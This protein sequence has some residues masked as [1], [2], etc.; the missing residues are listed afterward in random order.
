MG[1]FVKLNVDGSFRSS[2]NLMCVCGIVCTL[3]SS[4]VAGFSASFHG[5]CPLHVKL[6]TLK[7]G[8]LLAWDLGY[9]RLICESH[10]LDV[11]CLLEPHIM[12][13]LLYDVLDEVITIVIHLWNVSFKHVLHEAN[14]C[15]HC[16]VAL[17]LHR[18][19]DFL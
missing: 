11:I 18:Q 7:H 1:Y 12:S 4:R 17:G 15:D 3:L 9:R 10:S 14:H 13:S 19:C 6:L 8:L 16:L 5:S 2:S